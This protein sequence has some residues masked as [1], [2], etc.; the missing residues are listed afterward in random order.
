M[1]SR[2]TGYRSD[3][4]SLPHPQARPQTKR[5]YRANVFAQRNESGFIAE[6]SFFVSELQFN[7]HHGDMLELR[8]GYI[9]SYSFFV[10]VI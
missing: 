2:P 7:T 1:G 8:D 4:A 10:Q 3:S 5:C 9:Y 6:K